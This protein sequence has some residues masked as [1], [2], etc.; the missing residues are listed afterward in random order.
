[1]LG[2]ISLPPLKIVFGHINYELKTLYCQTLYVFIFILN[3]ISFLAC[4]LNVLFLSP[5]FFKLKHLLSFKATLNVQPLALF[6]AILSIYHVNSDGNS[7]VQILILSYNLLVSACEIIVLIND[8]SRF[9][10]TIY[11]SRFSQIF[12]H[13]FDSK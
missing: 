7:S 12:V 13:D 11:N 5:L 3:A 10:Q 4:T 2:F 1:M 9:N 8:P 6:I